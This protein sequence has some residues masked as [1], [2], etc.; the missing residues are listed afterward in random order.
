MLAPW[1]SGT[2]TP[3]CTP[4]T[5]CSARI[6]PSALRVFARGCYVGGGAVI[7]DGTWLHA[8]VTIGADCVLGQCCIVHPGAVIGSDGFGYARDGARW[9]KT[10]QLGR[11]TI[12]DDVEIGANT[13]IDRGA[14]GG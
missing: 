6:R 3:A 12:G 2:P 10:P 13:T 11:V 9:E 8:N 5:C 4:V 14:L 1:F 7:G